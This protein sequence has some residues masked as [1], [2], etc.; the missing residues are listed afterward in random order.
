MLRILKK[1][2]YN[3]NLNCGENKMASGKGLTFEVNLNLFV[4]YHG[5]PSQMGKLWKKNLGIKS[6]GL[7]DG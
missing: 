3:T 2:Q 4:I 1:T 7:K 5:F 6:P